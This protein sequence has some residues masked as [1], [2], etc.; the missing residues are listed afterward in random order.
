MVSDTLMISKYADTSLF[1]L[2][3]GFTEKNLI[4]YSKKLF[5]DKKVINMGY[6]LNDIDFSS[7]Y[8]YGYNYGYGYGYGKEAAK[9]SWFQ[10]WKKNK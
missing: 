8:G 3:S 2:R 6:V 9:K 5:K 10:K 7:S 4:W 1:V